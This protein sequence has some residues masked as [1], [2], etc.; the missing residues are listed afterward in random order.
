MKK[1]PEDDFDIYGIDYDPVHP[2]S[3]PSNR[4]PKVS[5]DKKRSGPP[6][7]ADLRYLKVHIK[8]LKL[9]D[10]KVQTDLAC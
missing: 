8:D 9:N 7:I 4:G 2:A 1:E 3:N 10:Q 6:R 5:Q